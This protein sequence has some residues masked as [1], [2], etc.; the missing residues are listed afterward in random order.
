[1]IRTNP[2]PLRSRPLILVAAGLLLA[3]LFWLPTASHAAQRLTRIEAPRSVAPGDPVN[4]VVHGRGGGNCAFQILPSEGPALGPF[5]LPGDR[6]EIAHRF[7]APGTYR[8]RA[9]GR[10][11]ANLGACGGGPVEVV[12]QVNAPAPGGGSPAPGGSEPTPGGGTPRAGVVTHELPR[13]L[14]E[15]GAGVA[16]NRVQPRVAPLEATRL[17]LA[18]VRIASILRTGRTV[19]VMVVGNV[20]D[21]ACCDIELLGADGRDRLGRKRVRLTGGPK[22]FAAKV[23]FDALP[24]GARELT[25][26]LHFDD[27]NAANNRKTVELQGTAVRTVQMREL[28]RGA[29]WIEIQVGQVLEP[30]IDIR[31]TG[32]PGRCV[33]STGETP[34]LRGGDNRFR[35][36][37]ESEGDARIQVIKK[38]REGSELLGQLRWRARASDQRLAGFSGDGPG[39]PDLAVVGVEIE[40]IEEQAI[41]LRVAVRN[42]GTAPAPADTLRVAVVDD[43]HWHRDFEVPTLAP[44]QLWTRTLQV[45]NAGRYGCLV[46]VEAR[47]VSP[48][49]VRV[50]P[51]GTHFETNE[52]NDGVEQRLRT[53]IGGAGYQLWARN[54]DGSCPTG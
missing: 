54:D 51:E 25:A 36:I 53:G 42:V 2:V 34:Y 11:R 20:Q 10:R 9:E 41:H 8:V 22:N 14:R 6:K 3:A 45:T 44:N 46:A 12:V 35:C 7:T 37:A 15:T 50:D 13:H 30:P 32:V 19:T 23:E 49:R 31:L 16:R 24:I 33:S 28:R 17:K 29:D 48:L 21:R 4:L 47:D 5:G 40:R 26:V 52:S 38:T 43:W 39:H 1:M 27:A 18:D